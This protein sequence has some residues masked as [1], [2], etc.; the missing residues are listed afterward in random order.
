MDF[1]RLGEGLRRVKLGCGLLEKEDCWW[2]DFWSEGGATVCG[3]GLV[4][5]RELRLKAWGVGK[6]MFQ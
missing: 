6:L 2:S 5:W 1:W 3:G 4:L